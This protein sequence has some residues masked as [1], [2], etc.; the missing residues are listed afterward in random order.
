[1]ST[2]VGK[3]LLEWDGEIEAELRTLED[4]RQEIETAIL[5]AEE[6]K[7]S[8]R[9]FLQ[10]VR[11]ALR[12][13]GERARLAAAIDRRLE[14]LERD[15][16]AAAGESLRRRNELL[17]LQDRIN[18]LAD[19]LDHLGRARADLPDA[20]EAKAAAENGGTSPAAPA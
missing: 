2:S 3:Q 1:M 12:S 14:M 7:I 19:A 10:A 11:N 15:L 4:K 17:T 20:T 9:D 8:K 13:R 5:A 18:D 16:H 6:I